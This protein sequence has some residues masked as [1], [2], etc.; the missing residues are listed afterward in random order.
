[1]LGVTDVINQVELIDIYLTFNPKRKEYTFL[2]SQRI[3]SKID[4]TLA[5]K[6]NL[7]RYKKMEITPFKVQLRRWNTIINL[8]QKNKQKRNL[9]ESLFLNL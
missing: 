4:G 1:M 8:V 5:H 2:A 9:Q 6:V 7:S 3:F